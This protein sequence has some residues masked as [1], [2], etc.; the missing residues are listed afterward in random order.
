V[1]L[2]RLAIRIDPHATVAGAIETPYLRTPP[3]CP[4]SGRWITGAVFTY[5]DGSSQSLA[6]GSA[7]E[8][9]AERAQQPSGHATRQAIRLSVDPRDV[10]AG[11]R[12]QFRFLATTLSGSALRPVPATT[13][14]FAGRSTQTNARGRATITVSFA[15]RG[16]HRAIA[17]KRGFIGARAFVEVRASAGGSIGPR[18]VNRGALRTSPLALRP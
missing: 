10:R 1:S 8:T 16:R 11:R 18:R 3:A 12:V 17:S 7:C 14:R 9:T 6:S 13:I 4:A 15:R 5:A 2:K